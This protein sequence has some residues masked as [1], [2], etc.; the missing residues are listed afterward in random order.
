MGIFGLDTDDS[1]YTR[2]GDTHHRVHHHEH[3]HSDHE[4]DHQRN[5]QGTEPEVQN[6]TKP[7]SPEK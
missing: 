7:S 3:E 5:T 4:K 6:E 1:G 2:K